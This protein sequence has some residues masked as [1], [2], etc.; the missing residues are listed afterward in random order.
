MSLTANYVELDFILF[1]LASHSKI[2]AKCL[3]YSLLHREDQEV[4]YGLKWAI[5]SKGVIVKD[6]VFHNLETSQLQKG[7]ATYPGVCANYC[8]PVMMCMYN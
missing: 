4:S 7:G 3:I 6:K 8:C 5:A 1:Y 2:S